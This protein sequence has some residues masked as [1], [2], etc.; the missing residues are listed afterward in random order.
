[1]SWEFLRDTVKTKLA[2]Q[3]FVYQSTEAAETGVALDATPTSISTTAAMLT[4]DNTASVNSGD[5][6]YVVPVA[7][8]L[9]CTAAGDGSFWAVQLV[10]DNA[11]QWAS[12]GTT[13]PAQS[14]YY[15]TRTTYSNR[16]PKG[17]LHF[18]DLTIGAGSSRKKIGLYSLNAGA[19]GFV[20]GDNIHLKFG[21][22]MAPF[23]A[24]RSAATEAVVSNTTVRPLPPV[25]LG[26]GSS[27]ILQPFGAST[28]SAPSFNVTVHTM[29]L[30]HPRETA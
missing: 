27:L 25:F 20:I 4:L 30:G 19:S 3:I 14:T 18:G 9:I 10:L 6:H 15:D 11:T 23:Q 28:A 29:E 8:D 17:E 1:M 16:T 2:E 21:G 13:P 24:I 12:G 26:R 5:N 22:D 7:I